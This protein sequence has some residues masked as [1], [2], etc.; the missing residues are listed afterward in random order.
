MYLLMKK[1]E[2]PTVLKFE[3]SSILLGNYEYLLAVKR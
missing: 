2:T 3:A 1:D